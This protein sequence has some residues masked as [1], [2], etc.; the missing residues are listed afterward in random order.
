MQL[1]KRGKIGTN[2]I[3]KMFR[4]KQA[5]KNQGITEKY[6]RNALVLIISFSF[7]Q[8]VILNIDNPYQNLVW[9]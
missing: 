2:Y 6:Y 8:S 7:A 3:K 5:I 1:K 9:Q 4:E